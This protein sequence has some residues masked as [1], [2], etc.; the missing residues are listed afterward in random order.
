MAMRLAYDMSYTLQNS[1]SNAGELL[2]LYEGQ[3][4]PKA[5]SK[6]AQDKTPPKVESSFWVRSIFGR[7]V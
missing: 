5:I 2:K 4:L 7:V 6:N 1:K 3:Y